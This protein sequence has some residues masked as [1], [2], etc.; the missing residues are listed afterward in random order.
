MKSILTNGSHWPLE[1]LDKD[2]Q[3]AD[4][5]EAIEFRNHKGASN[6]LGSYAN[7]SKKMSNMDIASPSPCGEQ[8]ASQTCSLPQLIFNSKIPLTRQEK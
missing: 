4:V 5:S 3:K 8:N 2:L 1:H 7:L 6:N